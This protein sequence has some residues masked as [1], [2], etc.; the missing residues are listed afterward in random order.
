VNTLNEPNAERKENLDF[1]KSGI[2][3]KSLISSNK[4]SSPQL[5]LK[6]EISIFSE[7]GKMNE[8]DKLF[9][10]NYQE[11]NQN[12]NNNTQKKKVKREKKKNF[13]EDLI[14]DIK[15]KVKTEEKS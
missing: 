2:G 15:K 14:E 11:K 3:L 9:M 5:L 1:F 8:L 4:S 12:A 7:K 13:K 6:K 10:P